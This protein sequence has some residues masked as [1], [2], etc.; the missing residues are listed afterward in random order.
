MEYKVYSINSGIYTLHNEC[1]T[2][3]VPAAG[4]LRFKENSPLVG[5]YVKLHEGLLT[6]ICE[7]KNSF[8]RPKVANVDQVFI[9]MSLVE[10]DFQSFLM[11]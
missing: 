8:I 2:I 9:V 11:D 4:R 6:E 10:P 1:E 7:R 3:K 5:D